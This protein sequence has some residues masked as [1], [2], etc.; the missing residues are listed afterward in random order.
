M[1]DAAVVTVVGLLVLST[2]CGR[3][4]SALSRF[5]PPTPTPTPDWVGKIQESATPMATYQARV[6]DLDPQTGRAVT[7]PVALRETP[8][9]GAEPSGFSVQ[10]GERIFITGVERAGNERFFKV[11]SFDGLRRGWLA[12]SQIK[13]ED[14]PPA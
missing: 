6:N 4:G 13:A 11:R 7:F 10:P 1:R 12:E 8:G 2:G 3:I 5:G 9:R 14:R